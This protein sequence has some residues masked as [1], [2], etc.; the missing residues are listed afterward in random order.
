MPVPQCQI[1]YLVLLNTLLGLDTVSLSFTRRRS[2]LENLLPVQCSA[3]L[4]K[5]TWNWVSCLLDYPLFGIS[6]RVFCN[7]PTAFFCM[8]SSSLYFPALAHMCLFSAISGYTEWAEP[9]CWF[10]LDISN[11]QSLF[12]VV[13]N[14]LF[15]MVTLWIAQAHILP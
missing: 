6:V 4:L 11:C 8:N 15:Y 7:F 3:V 14:Y 12:I 10:V 9:F 2:E 5:E 13:S 1:P